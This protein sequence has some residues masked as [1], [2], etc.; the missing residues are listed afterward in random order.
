MTRA[1]VLSA[2]R[3]PVG[4]YGGA[5]SGVRP[6]DL[7][8]LAIREAV[9]RAGVAPAEIVT[10][11]D[12]LAL[13]PDQPLVRT[14]VELLVKQLSTLE[15]VDDLTLTTNGALLAKKARALSAAGLAR[16]TVSLDALDDD[17]FR[18]MNDVDFA[19]ER[20][21]ELNCSGAEIVTLK[22]NHE[23]MML[24]FLGLPGRYGDS[25]LFNGGA[26]T[27]PYRDAAANSGSV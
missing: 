19:V 24:S 15:G 14:D 16:V 23:D 6:D 20:V 21:L 4:R 26:A 18:A 9:E 2:V 7:A 5:L 10:W 12:A 1:V 17:T 8:A 22:G 27:P 13:R 25:F 11:G 3:T